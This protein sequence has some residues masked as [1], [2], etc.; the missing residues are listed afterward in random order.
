M[1]IRANGVSYGR[2]DV[3]HGRYAMRKRLQKGE[4]IKVVLEGYIDPCPATYNDDGTSIDFEIEVHS[5]T[6]TAEEGIKNADR[7]HN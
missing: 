3:L 1:E 5:S 7:A 2:V 6:F 4:R